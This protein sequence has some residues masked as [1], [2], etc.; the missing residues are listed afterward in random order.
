MTALAPARYRIPLSKLFFGS[1]PAL[2]QALALA[3]SDLCV[4][5]SSWVRV[6]QSLL[7][8]A[9]LHSDPLQ[10]SKNL[11]VLPAYSCN[12][13]S[14]AILL[15]GL[16]PVYAPVNAEG[17][18]EAQDAL[19]FITEHTLALLACTNTG[20]VPDMAALKTLCQHTGILFIEDAGYSLGGLQGNETLGKIG[21]FS[22]TNLSEGKML[23]VGG[24]LVLSL[25]K[26]LQHKKI[27]DTLSAQSK[28]WMPRPLGIDFLR[29][30]LFHLGSSNMGMGL[31]YCLKALIPSLSKQVFSLESTRKSESY[32]QGDISVEPKN[33]VE[34]EIKPGP[35]SWSKKPPITA[36]WTLN[37]LHQKAILQQ[38]LWGLSRLVSRRMAIG[39][40]SL[41]AAN[42]P[43]Q[44]KAQ[45]Y[46]AQLSGA[47]YMPKIEKSNILVKQPIL[48]SH[49]LGAQKRLELERWGIVKQYSSQW[50]QAGSDLIH[51]Q[52]YFLEQYSLPVHEGVSQWHQNQIIALLKAL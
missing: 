35:N 31:F 30:C 20:I 12:E 21:D 45:Y 16:Q 33:Q 18:M 14:K 25:S 47:F 36:V 28:T 24:G 9:K 22:I 37:P 43:R 15:A 32:S 11:V 38:T 27:A 2:R 3:P 26:D 7:I 52:R 6:L 29:L 44:K 51:A 19:P 48:I 4:Y 8:A 42:G 46:R 40:L 34:G 50:A 23:P 49:T 10:C 17:L 39:Y 13:F 5:G 1:P 41:T